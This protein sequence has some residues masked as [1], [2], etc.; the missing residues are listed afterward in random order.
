M[1]IYNPGNPDSALNCQVKIDFGKLRKLWRLFNWDF[2]TSDYLKNHRFSSYFHSGS[3]VVMNKI[4]EKCIKSM[5]NNHQCQFNAY[6]IWEKCWWPR[7][8]KICSGCSDK[9]PQRKVSVYIEMEPEFFY[10][11]SW[12]LSQL[13]QIL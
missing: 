5:K 4:S 10:K 3:L 9:W 2:V 12:K 6:T 8:D 11:W 7:A 13:L 1:L